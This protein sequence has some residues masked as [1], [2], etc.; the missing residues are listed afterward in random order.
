MRGPAATAGWRLPRPPGRPTQGRP[1]SMPEVSWLESTGVLMAAP[2]APGRWARGLS[3]RRVRRRSW[4]V[5]WCQ[6]RDPIWPQGGRDRA[7]LAA[8]LATGQKERPAGDKQDRAGSMGPFGAGCPPGRWTTRGRV[9]SRAASSRSQGPTGAGIGP[10]GPRQISAGS[11]APAG[12]S[13]EP[14]IGEVS[15][16][17]EPRIPTGSKRPRDPTAPR[18][19]YQRWRGTASELRSGI[20]PLPDLECQLR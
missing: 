8:N 16:E 10:E 6:W 12:D 18:P 17:A 19:R 2:P 3:G 14:P 9:R 11:R 5:G 15:V 7:T 20:T 4:P 1:G 13:S